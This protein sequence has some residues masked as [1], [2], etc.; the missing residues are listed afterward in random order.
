[1]S[2]QSFQSWVNG[3]DIWLACSV[4]ILIILVQAV[5]FLRTAIRE[6]YHLQ[7]TPKQVHSSI[8]SACITAAG[9]SLSPIIIAI[10]MIAVVGAPSAWFNLNNIGAARTELANIA[11]G[12]GFAGVTE[13]N[14]NIGP[15]AWSYALWTCALNGSG[16][17]VV[18]F[19]LTHRMDGITNK[20]YEKFDK[21]YV[22]TLMA[23]ASTS[24]F[25]Y[26][27]ANNVVGKSSLHAVAA[28]VSALC[29]VFLTRICAKN[30]I[31]QE[32]SLGIS[33]LAGMFV[34]TLLAKI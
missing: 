25:V 14:G 2:E 7:I 1:M 4:M 12:A 5:V 30:R 16:W 21:P 19:L 26:L 3:W 32:L 17:I 10:S 15:S 6:A 8:R 31:L 20:L 34:P 13:L 27:L 22:S 29:M 28:V 18:T 33:M 24:L 9:P 11:I 23:A